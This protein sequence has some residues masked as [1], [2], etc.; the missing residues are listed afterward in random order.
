LV[1]S[2][3]VPPEVGKIGTNSPTFIE[4]VSERSDGIKSFFTKQSPAKKGPA[5][6]PA[7]AESKPDTGSKAKS[8]AKE[9]KSEIVDGDEEQDL[10]DDS[11]APNPVKSEDEKPSLKREASEEIS[12]PSKRNRKSAPKEEPIEVLDDEDAKKP[13]SKRK[14]G[15]QTKVVRKTEDEGNEA[16]SLLE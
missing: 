1:Y 15:H 8:R 11:N 5:Q 14:G 9:L 16:V 6:T 12:T 2:F 7:K 13:S 4:P 10:G 3:P